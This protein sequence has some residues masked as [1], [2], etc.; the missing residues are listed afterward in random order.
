MSPSL[1]LEEKSLID[2]GRW[3]ARPHCTTPTPIAGRDPNR[4]PPSLSTGLLPAIAS[5][6]V[7][8]ITG[9]PSARAPERPRALLMADM[10][11]ASMAQ[12]TIILATNVTPAPGSAP[13]DGHE[14]APFNGTIPSPI[15]AGSAAFPPAKTEKPRPHVCGTCARSFARLE[16]LKRHERSHTKEKPFECPECTRCFARRDLLLR[17][18][19]KLHQTNPGS[20]RPRTARRESTSGTVGPTAGSRARKNSTAGPAAAPMRPRANTIS[21]VM[22]GNARGLMATG[23]GPMPSMGPRHGQHASLGHLPHVP[24]PGPFDLPGRAPMPV[25]HAAPH[26]LPRL[27]L[28]MIPPGDMMASLRTA[29]PL[30]A[31]PYDFDVDSLYATG[32]GSTI[33]PAQLHYNESPPTYA[34]PEPTS[35]YPSLYSLSSSTAPPPIEPDAGLAWHRRFELPLALADSPDY[36]LAE[37][38]P[39]ALSSTSQSAISDVM[40]DGSNRLPPG[41]AIPWSHASAMPAAPLGLTPF[42]LDPSSATAY[43]EPVLPPP[44]TV[45]PK[46]LL[47]H[48]AAHDPYFSTPPPT[49]ALSPNGIPCRRRK[50][51]CDLG[52]VDDPRDPPCVRCR[53]ESKECFFSATRRKRPHASGAPADAEL[54]LEADY[55]I[56]NGRKRLRE[57]EG[58]ADGAPGAGS[59]PPGAPRAVERVAARPSLGAAHSTILPHPLTPGGSNGQ[60]QPLRRP[61]LEMEPASISPMTS[62]GGAEGYS[63][64]RYPQPGAGSIAD[65]AAADA[66]DDEQ[67]I[68]PEKILQTGIYSGHDALNLLFE[69]AGRSGDIT[70]HQDDRKPATVPQSTG[71]RGRLTS[72]PANGAGPGEA[73]TDR[74]GRSR[75]DLGP[76]RNG[77]GPGS[78][79]PAIRHAATDEKP[80]MDDGTRTREYDEARRAWSRCRFVRAGWFSAAEA[81]AYIEYFYQYMAP[82]TPISPPLFRSPG[83]QS[84]LLAE[85]PILAVTL[86]TISSRYMR[87]SG[88]GALSRAHAIHDKLWNYLRGMIERMVWGQ[89]QF[90]SGFG[91]SQAHAEDIQTSSTA[92]WRGLRR[93]SMRTLGTVESLMLLTEWHPRALH[94][95]PGDDGLELVVDDGQAPPAAFGPEAAT[96]ATKGVGGR[97][98]ESWLEPAWRSDRMCWMLLGNALALSFEL[99]VFDPI[100]HAETLERWSHRPEYHSAAYRLRAGRLRTLLLVYLTQ[101]SGRLEW[102]NPCDH[103]DLPHLMLPKQAEH[104]AHVIDP[105]LGFPTAADHDVL[106]SWLE[107]TSLMRSGNELFFLSRNHTRELIRSGRYTSLLEHFQPRL[108]GWRTE[109]DTL[110]IPTY[111]RYILSIEFEY[112]TV[113]I[114]SLALQ[115]VVER[116]ANSSNDGVGTAAAMP[117]RLSPRSRAYAGNIPYSTLAGFYGGDQGY[118]KEV[119]DA[120]R[121]LLRTVV[122]GLLPG[123]YLQHAPVRTYFR[124]V[125]GAMFLLKTFALGAKEDEVALSLSLMD[126]TV[127]ALRTC[128]VD[129]VHLGIRFA[130]LLDVLTKRIR[131]RFVRMAASSAVASNPNPNPNRASDESRSPNNNNTTTTGRG[132]QRIPPAWQ[133]PNGYPVSYVGAGSLAGGGLGMGGGNGYVLYPS[134]IDGGPSTPNA[135]PLDGIAT[136]S[137]DPAT[138]GATVSIMPPPSS[139]GPPYAIDPSLDNAYAP[140]EPGPAASDDGDENAAGGGGGGGG[141]EYVA[142]WLALPLDPLLLTNT[143][144]GG[145]GPGVGGGGQ[146]SLMGA[147]VGG[148]DLLELLLNGMEGDGGGMS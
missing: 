28:H 60:A 94:F 146:T 117:D 112:L 9:A 140:V 58:Y 33:N 144:G 91:A 90:G 96:Q 97:R 131:S 135:N 51:R 8:P 134:S 129:D 34:K 103:S 7:R 63:P 14:A 99:G 95:P 111:M 92:P 69:A 5:D 105:E 136:E 56:R 15:H 3:P 87:L 100:P 68:T 102:P 37:S 55:E 30:G 115:A 109:F 64:Q 65:A 40:L 141:D 74:L 118:I 46:S 121:N 24:G 116:C 71:A 85:E 62:D 67:P 66:A 101:L 83:K 113:Y 25:H 17:H 89:E 72:P 48:F 54:D 49:A 98:I 29:P 82:L 145:A 127:F 77:A 133:P 26:A 76:P 108:K 84:A 128:V 93:G 107:L 122:D 125:S 142:D 119:V 50:V 19:Q 75:F 86:L 45:S 124:I 120:S 4:L 148:F 70:D 143:H 106:H 2:N 147:D 21:H 110:D 39:S 31:F 27:H 132:Y 43:P 126:S 13:M 36:A 23:P 44:G 123:G 11:A 80:P 57:D 32:P 79:D 61:T 137:M 42:L 130:D 38:S 53:R 35:P 41:D 104:L 10:S 139:F 12:A 18:Q 73:P 6:S 52:S 1:M 22:D 78:I 138:V 114:N 20:A 47:G 16:H 81:I 59:P 88:P